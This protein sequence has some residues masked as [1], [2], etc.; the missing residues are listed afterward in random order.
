MLFAS[1]KFADFQQ[2][3]LWQRKD[4]RCIHEEVISYRGI[5]YPGK[6]E[7]KN[8][9]KQQQTEK[10][11]AIDYEIELMA[12]GIEVY[13]RLINKIKPSKFD[14][15]PVPNQVEV[16][17]GKA[18]DCDQ[19]ALKK[20]CTSEIEDLKT[21]LA[22]KDEIYI[23]VERELKRKTMEITRQEK[24]SANVVMNFQKELHGCEI[25]LSEER[26][27]VEDLKSQLTDKIEILVNTERNF[28]KIS[29]EKIRQE[30]M[31]ANA[32]INFQ[33]E[34]DI[35]EREL[36]DEREKVRKLKA[37]NRSMAQEKIGDRK[38]SKIILQLQMDVTAR[39]E[40]EIKNL[41]EQLAGKNETL[42]RV[43]QE[44]KAQKIHQK[45]LNTNIVMKLQNEI[46]ESKN[47][48]S[49]ERE[50]YEDSTRQNEIIY[51]EKKK[52]A[53]SLQHANEKL[54]FQE[55]KS[56]GLQSI[57]TEMTIEKKDLV[58]KLKFE[59]SVTLKLSQ[60]ISSKAS[61]NQRLAKDLAESGAKITDIQAALNNASS[62]QKHFRKIANK[63]KNLRKSLN[64]R[65]MELTNEKDTQVAKLKK[66]LDAT[67][68]YLA[69]I[70]QQNK[71]NEAKVLKLTEDVPGNE[72]VIQSEE[73]CRRKRKKRKGGNTSGI[74]C[75]KPNKSVETVNS[76]LLL[77]EKGKKTLK[78]TFTY[79]RK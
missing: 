51:Q 76:L 79:L 31:N 3:M 72:D 54:E 60:A 19:L 50:K 61:E 68:A 30:K 52:L 13:E 1:K 2:N 6:V 36:E 48:L 62:D 14:S 27:K 69:T 7:E 74:K 59:K 42:H 63:E 41:R 9:A 33:R 78:N 55:H 45:M 37:D 25:E 49:K 35:V 21:K 65:L 58:E 53:E 71:Q 57:V 20:Q 16:D 56:E 23:T 24:M 39:R 67:K 40:F 32:K 64:D 38:S 10:N 28:K 34:L 77:K 5:K 8:V 47:E 11:R 44:V 4:P 17:K 70:S 43:L 15:L 29:T 46:N 22:L 26:K 12:K 75:L 18:I 73:K 66:K